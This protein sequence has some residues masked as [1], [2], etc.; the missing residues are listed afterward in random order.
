VD[1]AVLLSVATAV[2]TAAA[3]IFRKNKA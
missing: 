2:S 1:S 3:V